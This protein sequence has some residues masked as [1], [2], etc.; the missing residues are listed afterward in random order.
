MS[1]K[2]GLAV[3]FAAGMV[4]AGLAGLADGSRPGGA[5]LG[6]APTG[7]HAS[8]EDLRGGLLRTPLSFVANT[9]ALDERVAFWLP[10]AQADV[11]LTDAGLTYRLA[12]APS[13]PETPAW[14]VR[15]EFVGAAPVRPVATEAS[16]ATVNFFTGTPDQWHTSVPTATA[17]TYRDLWPGVDATYGGDGRRLKYEL[18]VAPGADPS[19]IRLAYRGAASV[20]LTPAGDLRVDSP[21]GGLTDAAPTAFQVVDGEK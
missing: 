20:A 2:R 14:V 6:G 8:G 4:V 5:G 19:L 1:I 15:Q 12:G 13:T 3:F 18:T 21:G 17:V 16:P 7:G 9:G 10:G 11:Y